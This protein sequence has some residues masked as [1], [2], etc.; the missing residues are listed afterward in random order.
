MTYKDTAPT[1]SLNERHKI[2]LE[3]VKRGFPTKLGLLF[4]LVAFHC[5]KISRD[6]QQLPGLYIA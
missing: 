4:F 3:T 1:I 2:I 6:I 5:F